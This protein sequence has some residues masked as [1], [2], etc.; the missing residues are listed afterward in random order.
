MAIRKRILPKKILENMILNP[1]VPSRV[2]TNSLPRAKSRGDFMNQGPLN[3]ERVTNTDYYF[4]L[5]FM[6]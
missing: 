1:C 4:L 5:S 6:L 2:P 3:L